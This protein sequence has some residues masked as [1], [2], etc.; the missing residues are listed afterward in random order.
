MCHIH[1][2]E[3]YAVVVTELNIAHQQDVKEMTEECMYTLCMIPLLLKKGK[4]MALL[5]IVI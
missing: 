4:T 5:I 1:K 2:M 3:Y